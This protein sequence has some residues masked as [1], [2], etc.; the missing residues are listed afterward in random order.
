MTIVPDDP[1]DDLTHVTSIVLIMKDEVCTPDDDTSVLT[2]GSG[3]PTEIEINE[4]VAGRIVATAYIP[5]SA[6]A[7]PYR[8]VWRADV[9][10]GATHRTALYG[11]VAVVDL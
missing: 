2:L 1:L 8:R 9:Y 5:A 11:P 4:Q 10:V 3:D 6:L 7:E